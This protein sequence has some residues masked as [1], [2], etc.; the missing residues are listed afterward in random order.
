MGF[1]ELYGVAILVVWI[2]VTLLWAIS[3]PLKDASIIDMFWG[4][5]PPR[6]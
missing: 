2:L 3:V 5:S 6:R 4:W 1:F